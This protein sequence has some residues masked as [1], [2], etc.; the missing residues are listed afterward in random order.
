MRIKN[1]RNFVI[2]DNYHALTVEN[3]FIKTRTFVLVKI[4]VAGS[5]VLIL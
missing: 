2:V 5:A 4:V 1:V 3:E